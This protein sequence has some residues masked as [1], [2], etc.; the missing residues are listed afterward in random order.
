MCLY[1]KIIK[2]PHYTANKKNNGRVPYCEDKRMLYIAVG[3]GK[4]I[5]CRKKQIRSWVARI[6]CE[7]EFNPLPAQFVT[8]TFD[9]ESLC[10]L[11]KQAEKIRITQIQKGIEPAHI[12][13][14]VAKRAMRLFLKRWVKEFGKT[15]RHFATT[16][17]G[18]EKGRIHIHLIT[19][20]KHF[21]EIPEIWKYGRVN[22]KKLKHRKGIR[23]VVKYIKK[24]S[25][26]DSDF[27]GIILASP[28]IGKDFI[29]TESARLRK[30]RWNDE[31]QYIKL[32]TGQKIGIPMYWRQKLFTEEQRMQ[33]WADILDKNERW[34]LG[35]K[36][37]ISTQKGQHEFIEALKYQQQKMQRLGYQT[38]EDWDEKKYKKSCKKLAN[39]KIN[40]DFCNTENN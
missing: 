1:P 18:E 20:T 34:I 14:I 39:V 19:W 3:C 13:N 9:E 36:F 11:T 2:N 40:T 4:C 38:D 15:L 7:R 30:Q 17:L 6:E 37:D 28:G 35:E 16:E 29:N 21:A 12:Y 32:E 25:E 5:E 26:I 10:N 31:Q 8:L 22:E 24:Q 27:Y 23:Y 33:Q